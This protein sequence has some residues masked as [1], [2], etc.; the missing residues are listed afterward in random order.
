MPEIAFEEVLAGLND[1][2]LTYLDVRNKTELLTDG[3]VVG[4][5]NIPLPEINE[6]FATEDKEFEEKYGF[7]KPDKT[8]S[9]IVLAC[10]SGVRVLKALE[11]LQ[12]IGYN[13]FRI[14]R[15]SF[16]DWQAKGGPI[17]KN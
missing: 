10:R 17:I 5:V 8:A 13:S 7:P 15:G 12:S 3:Q 6:A 11:S 1:K 4:S 14:Y 16:N 2:S 9:N